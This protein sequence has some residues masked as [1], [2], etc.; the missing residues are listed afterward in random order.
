MDGRVD[1][2]HGVLQ[3]HSGL[4]C[5]LGRYRRHELKGAGGRRQA[6]FDQDTGLARA[7]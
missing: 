2:G 3:D 5:C 7:G 4:V 1:G 6:T